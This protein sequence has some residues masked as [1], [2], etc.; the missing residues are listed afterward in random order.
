MA[1]YFFKKK[2]QSN[3][4]Y[5]LLICLF[6]FL[7]NYHYSNLGV[8]P[9]D[10][11]LHYDSAHKILNKEYP[12]RDYWIVSGFIVDFLQAIF[13]KALGTNWKSYILHSSIIN[14]IISLLTY[15]FFKSINLSNLISFFYSIC[16]SVVGYTISG[17]PFVDLHATYFC[18]I[19]FYFTVIA[20]KKPKK[21]FIW[22]IIIFFYLLAFFSK[23]VP[24]TYLAI[25][26]TIIFS[27]YF[28][29]NKKFRVIQIIF[30]SFLFYILLFFSLLE[31]LQIDYID[32]YAQ[33]IDYPREFGSMRAND[34][35]FSTL[36]FFNNYKFIILPFCL[37]SFLK[38]RKLI[39]EKE[40][41]FSN[42]FLIFL[43]YSSLIT[44]LLLHQILTKN[45]IFI[46]FLIPI[47]FAYI[48]SELNI[49]KSRQKNFFLILILLI[50]LFITLKYHIRYNEN[51]K[52][53]ELANTNISEAQ[54]AN[55][56]DK[57]FNNLR[58]KTPFFNGT[59]IEEINL[60]REV[61]EI[62]NKKQTEIIIITHYLFLDSITTKKI[63]SLNR[64][65]TLDGA[66]VPTNKSK[67]FK[68]YKLYIIKNLIKK[69]IE[70]IYFIKKENINQKIIKN[71]IDNI[72]YSIDENEIFFIYKLDLNCLVLS[73]KNI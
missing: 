73:T 66:S 22:S 19:A 11:F 47:T 35:N 29:V 57:S 34:T 68:Y 46:Y 17:T 7:I 60:L 4:I 25:L 32:F 38:V 64:T 62:I 65:Y 51:R 2:N 12:V 61:R 39:I 36:K 71:Y 52:F 14:I 6:S 41:I 3:F 5:I 69:N 21:I 24:T 45:Q 9:I 31:F 8:F 63:Y 28:I 44:S 70:E 27:I 26:N 16:F 55:I 59:A 23:Q 37:L 53:H 72:C 18:L 67:F 40:K 10:T 58:W 42:D 30:F 20:I 54:N 56:L 48:H 43:I 13:F 49:K 50:N 1:I 15:Y 33:Y